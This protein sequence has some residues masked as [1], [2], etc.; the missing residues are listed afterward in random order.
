MYNNFGGEEFRY[1]KSQKY[2]TID[3]E[4]ESLNL[5]EKNRPWQVAAVTATGFNVEE[6]VTRYVTWPDID[7]SKDAAR[8]TG[9]NI[10]TIQQQGESSLKVLNWLDEYIYNPEYKILW[11]NGLNFDTYIHNIWRREC[12]FPSDY[13]YIP[14]SIDVNALLKAYKLNIKMKPN[15]DMIEFQYRFCNF[16]QRGLKTNLGQACKDLGIPQEEGRFHDAAYDTLKTFKVFEGIVKAMD[17]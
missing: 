2:I 16:H 10:M 9:F 13:S 4:T 7:V 1:N 12:G 3:F 6:V 15:E 5:L 14:R 17:I 8:I 11:F